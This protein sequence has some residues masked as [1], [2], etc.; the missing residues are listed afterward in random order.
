M[1]AVVKM[2]ARLVNDE[3]AKCK[4]LIA[5]AIRKLLSSISESKLNDIYVAVRDWLQSD[6]VSELQFCGPLFRFG[7]S[8]AR[9][10]VFPLSCFLAFAISI[11]NFIIFCWSYSS[12][13]S[14]SCLTLIILCCFLVSRF[15]LFILLNF[16]PA[17]FPFLP[18]FLAITVVLS[19]FFT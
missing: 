8:N 14:F 4:R 16:M 10:I 12:F 9:R 19:I 5:F 2:A 3:S 7:A 15:Y 11:L 18:L 6:K 13:F 1:V 17:F